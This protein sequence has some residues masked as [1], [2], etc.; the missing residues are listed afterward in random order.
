M[1]QNDNRGMPCPRCGTGLL[2]SDRQGVEI[3]YCPTCRGIWLDQGELDKIIDR[4]AAE[5]IA[6]AAAQGQPWGTPPDPVYTNGNY[7]GKHG[8]H[9][10]D[11]HGHGRRGHG[12]HRSLFSRIFD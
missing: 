11:G 10:D 9:D 7:R 3:D 6:R 4:S 1:T 5:F 2:M 12:R 8:H